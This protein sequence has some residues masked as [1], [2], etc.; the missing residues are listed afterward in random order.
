MIE[1]KEKDQK[2]K[3]KN[4]VIYN[5]LNSFIKL[6]QDDLHIVGKH[7]EDFKNIFIKYKSKTAPKSI[8]DIFPN[9]KIL[10]T[11]NWGKD[12]NKNINKIEND[13][14]ELSYEQDSKLKDNNNN[15]MN[16]TIS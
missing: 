15:P 12:K 13:W 6:F 5:C 10:K 11:K 3:K 8:L 2:E 1:L 4:E 9:S 16:T 7:E 14:E